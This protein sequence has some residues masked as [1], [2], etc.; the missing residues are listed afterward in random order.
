MASI[1]LTGSGWSRQV[2]EP[3][4]RFLIQRLRSADSWAL[5]Y[6]LETALGDSGGVVLEKED[7]EALFSLLE[8]SRMGTDKLSHR[9]NLVC[10]DLG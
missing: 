3:D 5:S 8:G 4:A 6:R 2:E 10:S 1:R 9:L 7:K